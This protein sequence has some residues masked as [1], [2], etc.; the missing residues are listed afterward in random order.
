MTDQ[1]L[2]ENHENP[3]S[4]DTGN[5]SSPDFEMESVLA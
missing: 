4:I 3:D 2:L 5:L 1:Q